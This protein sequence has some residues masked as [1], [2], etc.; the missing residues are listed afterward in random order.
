[1][2]RNV[3]GVE[4]LRKKN[5]SRCV[6]ANK[7]TKS[8]EEAGFETEKRQN[9][10]P[11]VPQKKLLFSFLRKRSHSLNSRKGRRKSICLPTQQSVDEKRKYSSEAFFFFFT[12][13]LRIASR[14][15]YMS[16]FFLLF[17]KK[18]NTLMIFSLQT[19]NMKKYFSVLGMPSLFDAFSML[20]VL[21]MMA[22]AFFFFG[23]VVPAHADFIPS[24]YAVESIITDNDKTNFTPEESDPREVILR[25]LN[26]F[27]DLRDLSL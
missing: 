17:T 16:M 11:F 4:R 9:V 3:G 12:I 25:V 2:K 22:S 14:S 10:L 8:S 18:E 7:K 26:Y 21:G 6:L 5:R 27:L 24:A 13:F 19:R 20:L 1:M 15:K 23:N